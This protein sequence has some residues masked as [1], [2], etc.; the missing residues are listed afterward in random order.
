M[1][2]K[3]DV[4]LHRYL[5]KATIL[6]RIPTNNAVK[7]VYGIYGI[8]Q[9]V[10]KNFQVQM[11]VVPPMTVIPEHTHPNVDSY[12]VYCGGHIMFSHGGKW[13]KTNEEVQES[14][15]Y[16]LS[17]LRGKKIRVKP[18]DLHGGCFGPSGGV[19]LSIQHW[20]NDVTPSCV[21]KDYDGI[22]LDSEHTTDQGNLN[23]KELTWQ[24]AASLEDTPPFWIN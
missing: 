16:D 18:N 9:C 22:A 23:F 13:V 20:I 10:Y 24:D 15:E 1:E 5:N 21:S 3:L 4:F 7:D 12:E 8:T 19:F 2:D 17:I 11:F 6:G 14:D